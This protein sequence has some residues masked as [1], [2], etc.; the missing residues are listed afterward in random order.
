V[1]HMIKGD[2]KASLITSK[3]NYSDRPPLF[4][5]K[6]INGPPSSLHPLCVKNAEQDLQ[7]T[8]FV[9]NSV[10]LV[11]LLHSPGS[12]LARRFTPWIG[13]HFALARSQVALE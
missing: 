3:A 9:L 6:V 11:S 5:A 7:D 1:C 13:R 10:R 12:I 4:V 2:S 8:S